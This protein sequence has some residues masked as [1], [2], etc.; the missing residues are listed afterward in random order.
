MASPGNEHGASCI[1][2]MSFDWASAWICIAHYRIIVK[3]LQCAGCTNIA[4]KKYPCLRPW[5]RRPV[6]HWSLWRMASATPDLR[7]PPEPQ[8][9]TA[10]WPV[11]KYTSCWQR[12]MCVCVNNLPKVVSW[13]RNGRGSNLWVSQLQHPNH[14]ATGPYTWVLYTTLFHQHMW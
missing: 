2:H 13:K 12:H 11:P 5:A 1:I 8:G 9:I 10:P 4:Q 14:Y 3:S 7:L 6:N